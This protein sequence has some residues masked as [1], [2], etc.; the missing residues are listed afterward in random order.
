M[1]KEMNEDRTE[2]KVSEWTGISENPVDMSF[3]EIQE[4]TEYLRKN[5]YPK[6]ADCPAEKCLGIRPACA[7]GICY[8]AI[9]L[10]D[11]F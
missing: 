3:E 4:A 1:K 2:W 8:V 10:C 5:H 9:R 11:D 6:P 7:L